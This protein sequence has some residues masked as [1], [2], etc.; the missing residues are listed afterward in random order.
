[1]VGDLVGV[2]V[3]ILV[4]NLGAGLCVE[5]EKAGDEVGDGCEI[6]ETEMREEGVLRQACF[7]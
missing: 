2:R 5:V 1:L 3:V 4:V 7:A 6:G